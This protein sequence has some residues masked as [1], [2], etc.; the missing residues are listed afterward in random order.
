MKTI[1]CFLKEKEKGSVDIVI[2]STMM[3]MLAILFYGGMLTKWKSTFL[4]TTFEK[5][6]VLSIMSADYVDVSDYS[7][8]GDERLLLSA[9]DSHAGIYKTNMSEGTLCAL[10]NTYNRFSESLEVN[11]N[12]Q[13]WNRAVQTYLVDK[14]IIY[15]VDGTNVYIAERGSSTVSIGQKGEVKT[16]DGRIIRQSGIYIKAT[17]VTKGFMGN[18]T[19]FPIENYVDL[20]E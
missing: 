16:P 13:Y 14:F 7:T 9:G 18:G 5:G 4:Y 6:I 11:L 17:L 8:Y 3:I 1:R 20:S 19:S 10:G 15:N 2:A 12:T